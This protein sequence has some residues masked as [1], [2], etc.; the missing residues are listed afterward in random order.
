MPQ[1][2]HDVQ[3]SSGL[4][5]FIM[6]LFTAANNR[7]IIVAV[8]KLYSVLAYWFSTTMGAIHIKNLY[9]NLIILFVPI[10]RT[11]K[12]FVLLASLK[13]AGAFICET[14]DKCFPKSRLDV[15]IQD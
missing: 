2:K 6:L 14:A 10:S 12:H 11:Q 15:Q 7:V 9:I 1:Y 13:E 5:R 8:K 4:L 3:G